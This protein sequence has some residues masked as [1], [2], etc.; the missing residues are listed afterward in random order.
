MQ[1]FLQKELVFYPHLFLDNSITT[2]SLF[3]FCKVSERDEAVIC[4]N[5]QDSHL[6]TPSF[7]NSL[8]HFSQELILEIQERSRDLV[9]TLYIQNYSQGIE[10]LQCIKY[11]R[12]NYG[13]LVFDNS[14]RKEEGKV[15]LEK[16]GILFLE[17]K[18]YNKR[19]QEYSKLIQDRNLELELVKANLYKKNVK[20]ETGC[21]L[22]FEGVHCG[23]NSRILKK[24]FEIVAP[25]CFVDY[26]AR[27]TSGVVRF[28]S[29]S[30]AQ[31]AEIYFLKEFISQKSWDD[32]GSFH[33]SHDRIMLKKMSEAE[34][35]E[36][37]TTFSKKQSEEAIDKIESSKSIQKRK[38]EDSESQEP[39]KRIHTRFETDLD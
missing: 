25:I 11:K 38:I 24:L 2:C 17:F 31:F 32:L 9:N 35:T 5:L 8:L 29:R 13:F 27:S 39:N 6:V 21:T 7:D 15:V 26:R 20:R 4:K 33:T 1:D 30:G 36:Y 19:I 18:E 23:T 28:K 14:S 3:P 37:Y 34:E 22:V 10:E 12:N 16:L